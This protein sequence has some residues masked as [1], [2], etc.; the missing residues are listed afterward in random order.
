MLNVSVRV[1]SHHL[2]ISNFEA[3]IQEDNRRKKLWQP[4]P[5][6]DR[7]ADEELKEISRLRKMGPLRCQDIKIRYHLDRKCTY[8]RKFEHVI[9]SECRLL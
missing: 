4:Q 8:C 9:V 1:L 6:E 5:K 2:L 7:Q 3:W